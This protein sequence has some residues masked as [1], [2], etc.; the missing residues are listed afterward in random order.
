MEHS[1]VTS[2]ISKNVASYT[3]KRA[4]RVGFGGGAK[5]RTGPSF[6]LSIAKRNL[7][8]ASQVISGTPVLSPQPSP[9]CG[10]GFK[11]SVAPPQQQQKFNPSEPRNVA[12][13]CVVIQQQQSKPIHS[14]RRHHLPTCSRRRPRGTSS[15]R[16]Q[17]EEAD[18]GR[19]RSATQSPVST[20]AATVGGSGTCE[21]SASPFT[22]TATQEFRNCFSSS[23]PE[24]AVPQSSGLTASNLES[25]FIGARTVSLDHLRSTPIKSQNAPQYPSVATAENVADMAQTP[26]STTSVSSWVSH[27]TECDAATQRV[28]AEDPTEEGAAYP[29]VE[30][31]G[32]SC[33]SPQ[34]T[35][36][37][38]D[39]SSTANNVSGSTTLIAAAATATT[40]TNQ[41]T[42]QQSAQTGL[43]QLKG[44]GGGLHRRSPRGSLSKPSQ[45]AV[46]AAAENL[47]W[48]SRYLKQQQTHSHTL[49]RKSSHAS[50]P[51][52][53]AFTRSN[54]APDISV[55]F[56]S[57]SPQGS[58]ECAFSRADSESE[59]GM[60][61]E[62]SASAGKAWGSSAA[63][64]FNDQRVP[65]PTPS[66]G[67]PSQQQHQ[68]TVEESALYRISNDCEAS[69]LLPQ[70]YLGGY[71]DTQDVG[72]MERNFIT[73]ILSVAKECAPMDAARLTAISGINKGAKL[74][75]I[76][77]FLT[78]RT[79]QQA[80]GE[81]LRP[82][83]TS[84]FAESD[85]VNC[86]QCDFGALWIGPVELGVAVQGVVDAWNNRLPAEGGIE[87]GRSFINPN[88]V[89]IHP[90]LATRIFAATDGKGTV[91]S[92]LHVPMVDHSD[93]DIGR[94]FEMCADFIQDG[95]CRGE[96]TMVHCR[97]GV[98]R[99][100]ATCM[101]YLM[102]YG[103]RVKRVK[104]A[105]NFNIDAGGGRDWGYRGGKC[106]ASLRTYTTM[107]Q[108][109]Q[110]MDPN[111]FETHNG[112]ST[113][114]RPEAFSMDDS[115]TIPRVAETNPL[116]QIASKLHSLYC[117][118]EVARSTYR[119]VYFEC[120]T[121]KVR[122]T[123]NMCSEIFEAKRAL[124]S[125]W[126][127]AVSAL[128]FLRPSDIA[129]LPTTFAPATSW[130]KELSESRKRELLAQPDT[131][132][133][134]TASHL[135]QPR[136]GG[137]L[138][139][140]HRAIRGQFSFGKGASYRSDSSSS[141][142]VI[143]SPCPTVT[144]SS[145]SGL[146]SGPSSAS[147]LSVYLF[148]W[149]SMAF[150][151]TVEYSPSVVDITKGVSRKPSISSM[152]PPPEV[153]ALS[154]HCHPSPS[155]LFI[156]VAEEELA[157]I[158]GGLGPNEATP[159]QLGTPTD[160]EKSRRQGDNPE[161]LKRIDAAEDRLPSYTDY[162][163]VLAFV[164]RAREEIGPNFGFSYALRDLNTLHGFRD[165]LA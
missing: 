36:S 147:T 61:R 43:T 56:N 17:E 8:P 145:W 164:K 94:W 156:R 60:S 5:Q 80:C 75:K 89:V 95:A 90:D 139:R 152:T 102:K 129:A 40:T 157:Q 77:L 122:R 32:A 52:S 29:S 54:S 158:Y 39:F 23:F 16:A 31:G 136:Q 116:Q 2:D 3:A 130:K 96:A 127:A 41:K 98:S 34:L 126:G 50:V 142:S 21:H 74:A 86:D 76:Q 42:Q 123:V 144:A 12:S 63:Q 137:S 68:P 124:P 71:S 67:T 28:D 79:A 163:E 121:C 109:T 141:H 59:T 125:S 53:V 13:S 57:R 97:V 148:S 30:F 27:C 7:A 149:Q 18:F 48:F 84:S 114:P 33:V 47:A 115:S 134:I 118:W 104:D 92:T 113:S 112:G 93:E 38:A 100:A 64:I 159:T 146:N 14:K 44:G 119:D 10:G 70:L 162:E 132:D 25:T 22:V 107:P 161:L 15:Q 35:S 9:A 37:S 65:S 26:N 120:D 82:K 150:P 62:H 88:L 103:I 155:S 165:L 49:G 78:T 1:R 51:A 154:F 55:A 69:R 151:R 24:P 58:S 153:F 72:L 106:L 131:I 105:F 111:S 140:Q 133:E 160:R 66:C 81:D 143:V 6:T 19:G 99:S 83:P 110:T 85:V 128:D 11:E 73:R 20:C 4:T 108:R 87:H 91:F 46:A 138:P 45:A 101:A 117:V 135:S